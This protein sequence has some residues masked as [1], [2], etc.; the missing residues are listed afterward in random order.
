MPFF[1]FHLSGHLLLFNQE[2]GREDRGNAHE[3]FLIGF[4]IVSLFVFFFSIPR[5]FQ[6]PNP[7]R[8]KLKHFL[9]RG[10]EKGLHLDEKAAVA[11]LMKAI[12]LDRENPMGYAY[13][14]MAYL[15]FY[16]TAFEE[17]EKKMKEAFFLRS[18]RGCAGPGREKN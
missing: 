11:E 13:L 8:S 10:I 2:K 6:R 4:F 1:H 9:Q 16:E 17:K 3:L 14:A 18:R 15:F 12:E 5:L 7:S